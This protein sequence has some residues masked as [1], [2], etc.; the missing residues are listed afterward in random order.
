MVRNTP[1]PAVATSRRSATQSLARHRARPASRSCS[2]SPRSPAP[3][4]RPAPT[5]QETRPTTTDGRGDHDRGADDDRGADHH[6]GG[7]HDRGGRSRGEDDGGDYDG[8]LFAVEALVV[9]GAIVMGTKSSGVALGIWGG[10]GV[11][12]LV[13]VL[14]A[15]RPARRRSTRS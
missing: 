13:F 15:R 3:R 10:V 11:A 12:V 2:R 9:I 4:R 1:A 6:R 7:D 8:L 5:S 14:R